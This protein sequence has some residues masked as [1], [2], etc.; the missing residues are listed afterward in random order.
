MKKIFFILFL[1]ASSVYSQTENIRNLELSIVDKK[2]KDFRLLVECFDMAQDESSLISCTGNP[3][4]TELSGKEF[5]RKK[6]FLLNIKDPLLKLYKE[7]KLCIGN[8]ISTE[9]ID[10]CKRDAKRIE[11]RLYLGYENPQDLINYRNK[12]K[13]KRKKEQLK[14][15]REL[16]KKNKVNIKIQISE[17]FHRIK[18]LQHEINREIDN[19]DKLLYRI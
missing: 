6:E 5:M 12:I 11:K 14:K 7:E 16:Y 1:T 8:S 13:E 17:S 4:N 10:K 19:L 9:Y 3:A 15:K 18:T 2:V